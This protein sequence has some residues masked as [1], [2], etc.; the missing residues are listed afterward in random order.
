MTLTYLKS[1]PQ[2]PRIF[3]RHSHQ[4]LNFINNFMPSSSGH[5]YNRRLFSSNSLS[6]LPV[7]WEEAS[8][9]LQ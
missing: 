2:L 9:H 5:F 7:S 6:M 1:V 4:T 8:F 3:H